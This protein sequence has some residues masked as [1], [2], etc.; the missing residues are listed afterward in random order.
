MRVIEAASGAIVAQFRD[1]CRSPRQTEPFAFSHE[2]RLVAYGTTNFTIKIWD[3]AMNR[4]VHELSGHVW[5]LNALAFSRDDLRLASGSWDGDA[6]VWDMST[7]MM[8]A[9]PLR[10]HGSGVGSVTFSPDGKTLLTSGDDNT[11]RFWH[12]ATGREMLVLAN[13]AGVI[14]PTGERLV[15]WDTERQAA[16][17]DRIPSL[18]DIA[19][20]EVGREPGGPNP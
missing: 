20:E 15:V 6:R 10:G 19:K 1:V 18:M 16:R 14:S 17:I 12:V 3:L 7:G 2:G 4:T 13:A 11:V 8:A 5:Y 9:G